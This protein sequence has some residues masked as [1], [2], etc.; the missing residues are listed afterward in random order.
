MADFAEM[1]VANYAKKV[2]QLGKEL[3]NF[4]RMTKHL[5]ED[6]HKKRR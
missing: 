2:R 5:V 4:E 3:E 6:I 1:I